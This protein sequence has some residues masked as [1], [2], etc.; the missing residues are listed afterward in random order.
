MKMKKHVGLATS[1]RNFLMGTAAAASGIG[2]QGRTAGA[3][4]IL[5]SR[6]TNE[7][8]RVGFIG[9]G[10]RGTQLLHGFMQ[11]ADVEVAALCD[12]YQPFLERDE[13]KI[14]PIFVKTVGRYIRKMGEDFGPDVGRYR[15]FRELLDRDDID[16]VVISTPDHWHAIQ[17]IMACDAGKDVY[18]EKPLSAT[19]VEGRK[20]VE[21]A[22]RNKRVVQVGLQRRSSEAYQEVASV[23]QDGTIG[24]VTA[25]RA[26]RVSNM[27]PHG[28]GRYRRESP[29]QG[30][31]WEMWLGP[32][33]AQS[34][35]DNIAPYK[36]RWWQA[37]SSQVANWGVHL[38]DA[39]R[40]ALGEEAPASIS[41]HGGRFAVDDDR[42]I[43]DTMEVIF[44]FASGSLFNWAQYEA[45][46][47]SAL[48]SG[49]IEIRGTLGNLYSSGSGYLIEP[50]KGGQ[51]QDGDARIEPL[52]RKDLNRNHMEMHI[53]NFLDCVK[54]RERC[55]CDI[56]TG[57]RSNTFALLANIAMTSKSRL[58]WDFA[59]ETIIGNPRANE[60]LHYEYR[61]PWSLG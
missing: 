43:P 52:K 7:K 15:D 54:S 32:R 46:G 60:L 18:V 19:I 24:K 48:K 58:E 37:Y 30:L 51:F 14:D 33:K 50:S 20:M 16:A 27:S 5:S 45:S 39:T 17:T 28:I 1:R 38:F 23:I 22:E 44:E 61:E 4:A 26:Y 21:A 29:P 35:Q 55:V 53:R 41:A 36:F 10:N 31:D 56:E 9:V 40:W 2:W 12:V 11:E 13:S 57:H 25:V 6:N 47:G 49:E 3:P 42:T 59:T 8:I 34:Y